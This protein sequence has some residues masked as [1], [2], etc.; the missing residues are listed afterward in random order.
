MRA[1]L[2]RAMQM[3]RVAL[4]ILALFFLDTAVLVADVFA[5]GRGGGREREGLHA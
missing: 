2:L 1:A 5:G 4:L 3:R